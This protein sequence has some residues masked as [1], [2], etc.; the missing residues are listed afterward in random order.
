MAFSANGTGPTF[1]CP[2]DN[3]GGKLSKFTVKDTN[4]G[5]GNLNYKIGLLTVDEI[6][7]AGN[8]NEKVFL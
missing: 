2:D 1:I 4:N 5:N 8:I 7:F 6:L 3:N